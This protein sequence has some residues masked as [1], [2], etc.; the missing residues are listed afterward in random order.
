M[1]FHQVGEFWLAPAQATRI[2]IARDNLINE[3]E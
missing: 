1:A 3:A 2:H